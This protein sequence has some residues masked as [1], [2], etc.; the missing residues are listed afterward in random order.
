MSTKNHRRTPSV[1]DQLNVSPTGAVWE[2][3]LKEKITFR[4]LFVVAMLI[5][6]WWL[7]APAATTYA[8]DK[9]TLHI[10]Y[11]SDTVGYIEGC[12]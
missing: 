6:A 8:K 4:I 1:E 3:I 2:N 5:F 9:V 12:G 11:S 10:L 7:A